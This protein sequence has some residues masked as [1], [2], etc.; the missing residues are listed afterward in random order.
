MKTLKKIFK[1]ANDLLP[2]ID[3]LGHSYLGN[4]IYLISFIII[5]IFL[6]VV[7]HSTSVELTAILSLIITLVAACIREYY[8][9]KEEGNQWSWWDVSFTILFPLAATILIVF[10]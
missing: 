2:A 8:N 9:E 3:K 10:Q 1:I 6:K 7:L 4:W 5:T